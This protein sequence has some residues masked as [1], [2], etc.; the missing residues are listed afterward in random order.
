MWPARV[1]DCRMAFI[2]EGETVEARG[3]GGGEEGGVVG[4][5]GGCVVVVVSR[6]GGEASR[7][8]VVAGHGNG[9]FV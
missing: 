7:G 8:D 1:W 4:S 9:G 5:G 2:V 3:D 6:D